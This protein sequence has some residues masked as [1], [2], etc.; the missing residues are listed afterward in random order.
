MPFKVLTFTPF[1]IVLPS[2]QQGLSGM[3]I[4]PGKTTHISRKKFKYLPQLFHRPLTTFR[5]YSA[6]INLVHVCKI[7]DIAWSRVKKVSKERLFS[8]EC[9]EIEM[10]AKYEISLSL[11]VKMSCTGTFENG[12]ESWELLKMDRLMALKRRKKREEKNLRCEKL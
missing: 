10:W 9:S 6:S 1:E 3:S 12:R 8:S 4:M 5:C 11:F 2:K 7:V